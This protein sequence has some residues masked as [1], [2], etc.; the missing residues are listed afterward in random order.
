MLNPEFVLKYSGT[1]FRIVITILKK[2]SLYLFINTDVNICFADAQ[3]GLEITLPMQQ[4]LD[5]L[6][7]V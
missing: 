4:M 3:I 6:A 5:R 7:E 2:V 1:S